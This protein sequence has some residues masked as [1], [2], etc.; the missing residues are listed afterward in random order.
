M[1]KAEG[2]KR[3]TGR[4]RAGWFALLDEWG[5][6]GRPYRE[7]AEWLIEDHQLS[8]WWAQKLIVEYE[9]E[10]G[11]RKPGS[12]RDG[13]F[14]VTAS[15]TIGTS[16]DDL[17]TA[18]VDGR[19]RKRWLVNGSMTLK[20]STQDRSA[21]FEW[22]GGPTR[23]NIDFVEKDHARSAV[24]VTHEKLPSADAAATVKEMWK[25]HLAELKAVLETR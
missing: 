24:A 16:I 10:R 7:I 12:R 3:A 4:E 22:D 21:R 19:R 2:I 13:T 11:I 1:A 18:V 20:S 6:A 14:T 9:Q 25:E 8:R 23:V 15:T 17:Y 5:A